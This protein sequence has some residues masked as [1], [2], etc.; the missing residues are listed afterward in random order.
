MTEPEQWPYTVAA[1]RS[2]V[3]IRFVNGA[4]ARF[5]IDARSNWPDATPAVE[6]LFQGPPPAWGADT[7]R[8]PILRLRQGVFVRDHKLGDT[9]A[10]RLFFYSFPEMTNA[11]ISVGVSEGFMVFV[12][13][14]QSQIELC[15]VESN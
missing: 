3:W 1:S 7:L 8:L 11:A 6:V 13:M 15:A 4:Q 12:D 5:R 9:V 10:P 14:H 2:K